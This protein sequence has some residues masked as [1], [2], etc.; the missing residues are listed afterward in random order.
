MESGGV[1]PPF[2]VA[3]LGVYSI[4]ESGGVPSS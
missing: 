1:Q 3:D 2:G 4:G